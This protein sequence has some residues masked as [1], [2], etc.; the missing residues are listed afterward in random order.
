MIFNYLKQAIQPYQRRIYEHPFNQAL[1]SGTL[2]INKF[3]AFLQQD[4]VYLICL[5]N[6]LKTIAQRLPNQYH[7][8]IC[9]Q[10]SYDAKK[11]A[12]KLHHKYLKNPQQFSFYKPELIRTIPE[13]TQYTQFLEQ[14]SLGESISASIVS[15][16]PCFY[17]YSTLGT[18]MNQKGINRN[19]PYRLWIDSYSNKQFQT[20]TAWLIN[21]LNHTHQ[22]KSKT[23][24]LI[25]I[26][27]QSTQFEIAFWDSF[28]EGNQR[29][30]ENIP[31]HIQH[32][33]HAPKYI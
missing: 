19:N 13:I 4:E 21:Y 30:K 33:T 18:Y 16:L 28:F 22:D 6:T 25:Q 27:M 2:P 14:I 5:S 3:N 7:Q 20:S 23:E 15:V 17:I 8:K 24:E 9:M 1:A 26:F 32:N 11:T 12:E 29:F 31:V 10:L